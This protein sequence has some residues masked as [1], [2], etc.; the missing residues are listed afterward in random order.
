MKLNELEKK[1]WK[2]SAMVVMI[3]LIVL[4]M[5]GC[6]LG[7]KSWASAGSFDA[8]KIKVT[9][10]QTCAITPEIEAGG[11]SYAMAFQKFYEKDCDYPSMFVYARRKSM[12]GWLTGD[13]TAGNVSFVYISGSKET[14]E[15]S[16]KMLKGIAKIVNPPEK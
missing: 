9:E 11:G 5:S 7:Q 1:C 4:F 3:V 6:A 8:F 14:P 12:W 16:I 2:T 13:T 10:T 15:E